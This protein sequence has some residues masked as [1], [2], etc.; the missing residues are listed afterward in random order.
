MNEE[1]IIYIFEVLDKFFLKK[2]FIVWVLREKI[3]FVVVFVV[4]Y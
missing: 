2:D 4:G 1:C 3:G